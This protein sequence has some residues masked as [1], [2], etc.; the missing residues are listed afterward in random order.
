MTSYDKLLQ[1]SAAAAEE[2]NSHTDED[3]GSERVLTRGSD[4][5]GDSWT[6]QIATS[7]N[8]HVEPDQ[9]QKA[10]ESLT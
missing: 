8:G 6:E 3:R 9:P 7:S 4:N 1:R 2:G 5:S 10:P